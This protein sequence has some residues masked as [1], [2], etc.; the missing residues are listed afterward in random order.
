LGKTRT[1][2]LLIILLFVSGLSAQSPTPTKGKEFWLGFMQ[3]YTQVP[4]QERL[5]VIITAEQNTSGVVSIPLLGWEVPFDVIASQAT[6]I[7]VPNNLAEHIGQSDVVVNRGVRVSALDSVSVFAVN[8]Q[9]FSTDAT[10]VLPI[11]ALGTTYRISSMPSG[12]VNNTNPSEFIIV[13]TEDGTEVEITPSAP[14]AGGHPAGL[15]FS[16]SLNKGQSV[17]IQSAIGGGDLSGTLVRATE[18]SG[19]CRPFAVFSGAS[20][21][22][23]PFDGC[24]ACDHLFDQMTAVESWGK[25]FVAVPFLQADQY[26]LRLFAH[27]NN[28]VVQIGNQAPITLQ[29][30]EFQTL[31][32]L[33]EPLCIESDRP[34]LAVQ[35]MSRSCDVSIG[36]PTMIV[37]N[38]TSE[39]ISDVTF[40]TIE[41]PIISNHF[42]T[43]IARTPDV[44]SVTLDGQ[45]L[46]INQ[47]SLVPGCTQY[48]Y[49]RLPISVGSHRLTA[50]N[51]LTAYAYGVG[52]AESYGYSVG[53]F[54]RPDFVEPLLETAICTNEGVTLTADPNWFD[55]VWFNEAIP[56]N[57]LGEG[58]TLNLAYPFASGIY[59]A[60]G[61]SNVSG[62]EQSVSYLAES[63]VPLNV[64][65]SPAAPTICKHQSVTLAAS[66]LPGPG[67]FQ[68]QW[69][70][71]G[72]Q[73]Q[74]NGQSITISPTQSGWVNLNVNTAGGCSMGSQS[75]FVT[76]TGGDI[77][78]FEAWAE[79]H[80]ICSGQSIELQAAAEKVIM[81]DNFDPGISWGLWEN[82]SQ[83]IASAN[84]GSVSGNA[85]YFNGFGQ[86]SAT[87]IDLNTA[88]GGTI[89]FYL[90]VGQGVFPCDNADPGEDIVLEYSVNGGTNWFQIILL[91][92]D[93]YPE[94]TQVEVPI[95]GAAQSPTTRFRWRQLA[96]S[97]NNQDNWAIDDVYISANQSNFTMNWGPAIGLSTTSGYSVIASPQTSAVY[98]VQMTDPLYGCTFSQS[99]SIE[100]GTPFTL[101]INPD[102]T[103]CTSGSAALS[104]LP[105]DPGYYQYQWSPNTGS[106][107]GQFGPNPIVSPVSTTTYNVLVQNEQ[108]CTAQAQTTVT[109]GDV[110]ALSINTA[111]TTLCQGQSTQLSAVMNQGQGF[112][113]FSWEN[114]PGLSSYSG[115]QVIASPES[116]STYEVSA[117]HSQTGCVFTQSIEINVITGFGVNAGSDVS[118]CDAVGHQLAGW[119]ELPVSV[120]WQ[121]TALLD[122]PTSLN[123]T[124]IAGGSGVFTLN[125]EGAAGCVFTDIVTI[126]VILEDFSLGSDVQICEG[127]TATLQSGFGAGYQHLWSNGSGASSLTVGTPGIISLQLTSPE[128]CVVNDDIEVFV[129]EVPEVNLGPDLTGCIGEVAIIGIPDLGFDYEW[130]TGH[131]E[132]TLGVLQPGNYSLTANNGPCQA[133][134]VITVTFAP[135]PP[136][137]FGADTIFCFAEPP[138]ELILNAFT[139]ASTYL[140]ST[141]ETTPEV[142][143]SEAGFYSLEITTALGCTAEY[144]ILIEDRCTGEYLFVPNAFTP[145]GD[146]MNDEFKVVGFDLT[147]FEIEIWNRWGQLVYQSNDINETWAGEFR[148][149]KPFSAPETY[150]Y[151]IRYKYIKDNGFESL[152]QT[153]NGFVTVVK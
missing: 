117:T 87:T 13:A 96:N 29:G 33:T 5:D 14:T 22:K 101:E 60:V 136:R 104:V 151:I 83:G 75:V 35:F 50:N 118:L 56:N 38:S 92:Q 71:A 3:N 114:T 121:P 128:G 42:L 138:R 10:K 78:S 94:L 122:N 80:V 100:V 140:W 111:T 82:I 62:C 95:P 20:C 150:A 74:L 27:Y 103:L 54:Q 70:G 37:L 25:K 24:T 18:A 143:I 8:F 99:L 63:A 115:S 133:M 32:D 131:T 44:S 125:A 137:P 93:N 77:T 55:V 107:T 126:T 139:P 47:F 66:V 84:C 108:G 52:Q 12:N 28:T 135:K 134:D 146:G 46:G 148:D 16:L 88:Q 2:S 110:Y 105:S 127:E 79:S 68:Y 144:E 149:S 129:L 6:V 130:N 53:S 64:S 113:S 120:Q 7:Q 98:T 76:V 9:N 30:G 43:I 109:V 11:N 90:K 45:P 142:V 91:D 153:K 112:F 123:P 85:L 57:I 41:S 97:G 69:T 23:V 39:S 26:S 1:Y 67:A 152:P 19:N 36:D 4:N 59:T 132:S 21:T 119:T 17:Q 81:E 58:P 49:A 147:H 73:G 40:S 65:I 106:I 141:G 145:N 72:I 102:T 86:R 48:S 34:V 31:H 89:K 51:G 15:P 116:T 124:I 61:Q